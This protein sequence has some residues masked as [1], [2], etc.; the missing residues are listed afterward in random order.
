MNE[1]AKHF[2][3]GG[4]GQLVPAPEFGCPDCQARLGPVIDWPARLYAAADAALAR[5]W[6][7]MA[8]RFRTIA[9]EM[10]RW[11]DPEEVE[12]IGRALLGEEP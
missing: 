9:D 8:T 10:T 2:V 7:D 1:H 4:T 6:D 3:S 11:M 12:A 5:D